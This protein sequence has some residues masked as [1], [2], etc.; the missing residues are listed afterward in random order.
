LQTREDKV[1]CYK[2]YKQRAMKV[3]PKHAI[4]YLLGT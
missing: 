4:D 3:R 1:K 2:S